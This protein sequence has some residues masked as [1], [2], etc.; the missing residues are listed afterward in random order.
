MGDLSSELQRVYGYHCPVSQCNQCY[1]QLSAF[2]DGFVFECACVCVCKIKLAPWN[3]INI[4]FSGTKL[5][6]SK[7]PK[8]STEGSNTLDTVQ[9]FANHIL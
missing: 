9:T 2:S 6:L 8:E 7:M 3:Y 4:N 5:V 1:L